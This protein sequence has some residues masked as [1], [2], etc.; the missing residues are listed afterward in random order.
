[1]SNKQRKLQD[2]ILPDIDQF[3]NP[4]NHKGWLQYF[5][6]LRPRFN[7]I[8]WLG[9][10]IFKDKADVRLDRLYV[11]LY[12]GTEDIP[13][14]NIEN[15]EKMTIHE[16]LLKSRRF[17]I[18][19]DPGSGKSTLVSHLVNIFTSRRKSQI[20]AEIGSMIPAPFVIRDFHIRENISFEDLMD[21]FFNQ[22]FWPQIL[23][24]KELHKAA[25]AGQVLF[26]IDGLDEIGS[27]NRRKALKKAI[28]EQAI[29]KYPKCIWLLT[30]RKVGYE[31]VP[32][33]RHGHAITVSDI[34]TG[35]IKDQLLLFSDETDYE[36]SEDIVQSLVDAH[37]D[38]KNNEFEIDV[39]LN[40][41]YLLPFNDEQINTFIGKYYEIR[42]GDASS[43][44]NLMQSLQEALKA[45]PSIKRLAHTPNLLT[46]IALVQK[47]T[48]K[49]P[50]G[51]V[52]L[53]D[54]I[55][56]AYL[57]SIDKSKGIHEPNDDLPR[58]KL[59]LA[60]LGYDMQRKRVAEGDNASEILV[61]EKQVKQKMREVLG[62]D[63][64]LDA[65]LGYVARR[66]GLLLPKKPGFFTFVHLSFQ[67]YFAAIWLYEGLI[68][69]TGRDK[70]LENI[71]KECLGE[72][73][74][75]W[76]ETLVFLFGKLAPHPG[77]SDWLF[78][79][80]ILRQE[81]LIDLE[82]FLLMID[83]MGDLKSGLSLENRNKIAEKVFAYLTDNDYREVLTNSVNALP[84]EIWQDVFSPAIDSFF[85]TAQKEKLALPFDVLLFL[86]RLSRLDWKN[87]ENYL[88]ESL[89]CVIPSRELF[90]LYPIGLARKGPILKELTDRLPLA[91]WFSD[92]SFFYQSSSLITLYAEVLSP[93]EVL[94]R[95]AFLLVCAGVDTAVQICLIKSI[96]LSFT[97]GKRKADTNLISSRDLARERNLTLALAR[98]RSRAQ[99]RARA[100]SLAQYDAL[101]RA[102]DRALSRD[103]DL[104]QALD[105]CMFLSQALD[106][107]RLDYRARSWF[108]F[109]PRSHDRD[110]TID[111]AW[112]LSQSSSKPDSISPGFSVYAALFMGNDDPSM[113]N[114]FSAS[115]ELEPLWHIFEYISHVSLGLR[116][117]RGVEP[118]QNELNI[119]INKEWCTENLP[120]LREGEMIEALELLGLINQKD[121][122]LFTIKNLKS[123]KYIEELLSVPASEFSALIDKTLK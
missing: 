13:V 25:R 57:E 115:P 88:K 73:I 77:A 7:Y 111:L 120:Y 59:W 4:F 5:A 42:I 46:I 58:Q 32:F 31:D 112:A 38:E 72:S 28:L 40:R 49:L 6:A 102:L 122:T 119:L 35:R 95:Q 90:F 34:S 11:P 91:K 97:L 56:E 41:F 21:Q 123:K 16:T 116:E 12:L 79:N 87:L 96:F 68:G 62:D 55:T 45:S 51:R 20:K 92:P 48:T 61:P 1:M 39:L 94:G 109:Q 78:E 18:L 99:F 36:S 83:L 33:D 80:L 117:F 63:H 17:I 30:S 85:D 3:I 23:D 101:D 26:L 2:L 118:I 9:L 22:P 27:I 15:A 24:R 108:S 76:R 84:E 37:F 121:D 43:R 104:Y 100:L 10:P 70:A 98:S 52:L 74:N 47:V 93:K 19:G 103:R 8:Q 105:R 67:E 54:K 60:Q 107:D 110:W 50:S 82:L 66:S 106:V 65:E 89:L 29:L 86:Q 113:G 44:E 75:I 53:Y 64:D 81:K 14:D 69:F 71:R 114:P